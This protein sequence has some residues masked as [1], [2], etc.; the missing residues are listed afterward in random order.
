MRL[1]SFTVLLWGILPVAA[2][3]ANGEPP[4]P[5]PAEVGVRLEKPAGDGVHFSQGSGVLLGG[6]LV[7]T[8]AHVVN[9]NPGSTK[10][11]VVVDGWRI[12]GTLV[13]DGSARK[14]DLALIKL[15]PEALSPRRRQ[16]ASVA[17][18]SENPA[19][20]QD[21]TVASL[22]TVTH[23]STIPTPITSDG[24]KE[25]WTNLLSTG[26]HHG[27]SGGGV[28]SSSQGCL[29]GI[30]TLELSGHLPDNGRFVDLT[31]FVPASQVTEFLRQY[32]H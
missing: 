3:S 30:L 14:L 1:V 11:T 17:V 22:G 15:P 16:Q 25:T 6:G 21:V 23:S 32:A 9:V 5:S 7:L 10:V 12:D 4:S 8:A 31:A 2:L 19:P 26:Y 20:S 24:K 18:C 28:F 29:W 13:A 27:N